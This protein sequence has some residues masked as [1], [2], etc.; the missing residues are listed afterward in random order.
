[1]SISFFNNVTSKQVFHFLFLGCT[2]AIAPKRCLDKT[3]GA[4]T[5]R[6]LASKQSLGVRGIASHQ[7]WLFT[8]FWHVPIPAFFGNW[9]EH[10]ISVA[11]LNSVTVLYCCHGVVLAMAS[12]N[13][14]D[15][16]ITVQQLAT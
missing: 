11:L 1:L 8:V 6:K 12:N 4:A 16:N 7:K 13:Q 2:C 9:I 10:E 5:V 15:S 3:P 14:L